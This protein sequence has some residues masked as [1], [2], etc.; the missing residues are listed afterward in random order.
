MM[1][2]IPIGWALLRKLWPFIAIAALCGVIFVQYQWV[3]NARLEKAAAEVALNQ[4]LAVNERNKETLARFDAEREAARKTAE[5]AI[6]AAQAR[7][8]EVG[9]LKEEL[10]NAP[11]ADAPAGDYLDTLSDRLRNQP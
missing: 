4:A 5:A 8:A 7:A 11:G 3:K 10:R 9:K 2:G 1:F 6:A